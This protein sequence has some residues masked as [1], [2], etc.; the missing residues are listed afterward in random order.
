MDKIRDIES[1]SDIFDCYYNGELNCDGCPRRDNDLTAEPYFAFGDL[2]ADV[3][4]LGEAPGGNKTGEKNELRTNK[5]IWKDYREI[6]S[7]GGESDE[8]GANSF[9]FAPLDKMGI[10]RHLEP[11][12]EKINNRFEET[13]GR[14]CNFY[15]TNYTKCNDIHDDVP[16]A[17]WF[18][19]LPSPAS[20]LNHS[21][22]ERCRSFFSRELELADPSAILIFSKGTS[23]LSRVLTDY[24][25]SVSPGG[26][27][28]AVLDKN[29]ESG[30]SP[31]RVYEPEN[32]SVPVIPS[33]HFRQG[34]GELSKQTNKDWIS[35]DDLGKV[36]IEYDGIK[37][38]YA[39]ELAIQLIN[40][41]TE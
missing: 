29:F 32:L 23:H 15:Y 41:I 25:G 12:F 24:G 4:I 19:D 8:M 16:E 17:R 2:P 18:S 20:E 27:T 10:F 30:E 28:D 3:V 5:R 11:F 14:E 36:D 1:P 34:I 26:V 39:D 31:I 38:Q 40:R 22:T 33:Y 9:N 37:R 6:E 13:F 21:G 35:E 7:A